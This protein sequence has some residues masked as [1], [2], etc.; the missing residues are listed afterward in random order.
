[1]HGNFRAKEKAFLEPQSPRQLR[2]SLSEQIR[3]PQGFHPPFLIPHSS[4]RIPHYLKAGPGA[5]NFME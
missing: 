4:F 1:M 5:Q 2:I 3:N